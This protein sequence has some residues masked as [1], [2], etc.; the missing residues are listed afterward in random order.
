MG[1]L[2]L[3]LI[4]V[5][6]TYLV[7]WG[8]DEGIRTIGAK[9]AHLDWHLSCGAVFALPVLWAL[10]LDLRHQAGQALGI[11]AICAITNPVVTFGPGLFL[12]FIPPFW[13][14]GLV[15]SLFLLMSIALLAHRRLPPWGPLLWAALTGLL[16]GAFFE[17]ARDHVH[18]RG[19]PG[20]GVCVPMEW[21]LPAYLVWQMGLVSAFAFLPLVSKEGA[22]PA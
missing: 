14:T 15:S 6:Y 3:T 18:Y 21:V 9:W 7:T 1:A 2:P 10:Q 16:G 12:S 20:A 11:V 17:I 22:R 19:C 13:V 5:A 4:S 8:M